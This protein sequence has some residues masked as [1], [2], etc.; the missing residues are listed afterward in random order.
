MA[1]CSGDGRPAQDRRRAVPSRQRPTSPVNHPTTP[2]HSLLASLAAATPIKVSFVATK[3]TPPAPAPHAIVAAPRGGATS[4]ATTARHAA[5]APAPTPLRAKSAVA[6][7]SAAPA[8][9]PLK[10]VAHAPAPAALAAK[11]VPLP[12]L[13]A[14]GSLPA[15]PALALQT[16]RKM[17]EAADPDDDQTTLTDVLL[18][19]EPAKTPSSAPAAPAP[20]APTLPR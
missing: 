10:A 2:P 8:P 12:A 15:L 1:L 4:F 11:T 16:G 6:A 14:V 17:L 13:P 7:K 18:L 9:A 20:P 19:P 3:P 5:P